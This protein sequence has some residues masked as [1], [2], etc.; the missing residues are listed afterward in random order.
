VPTGTETHRSPLHMRAH[1]N[2]VSSHARH[3]YTPPSMPAHATPTP[4]LRSLGK[5]SKLHETSRFPARPE[6]PTE[7]TS[8][9]TCPRRRLPSRACVLS[10]PLTH[11]TRTRVPWP[12]QINVK[13]FQVQGVAFEPPRTCH[14]SYTPSGRTHM[15]IVVNHRCSQYNVCRCESVDCNAR[16]VF[17]A[18][19]DPTHSDTFQGGHHVRRPRAQRLIPSLFMRA[20]KKRVSCHARTTHIL[21]CLSLLTRN[22]FPTP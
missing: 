18:T 13:T 12:N 1:K 5:F 4:L 9:R 7:R 8:R 22:F 21:P 3:T 19:R 2:K 15:P 10:R 17:A 20:H 14:V 6:P 16:T 11:H